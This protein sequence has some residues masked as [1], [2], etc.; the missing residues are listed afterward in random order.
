MP[1]ADVRDCKIYYEE[2][3]SGFPLL[4]ISG[5]GGVSSYWSPQLPVFSEQF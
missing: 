4:L 2:H 5:L 1:V 3:G